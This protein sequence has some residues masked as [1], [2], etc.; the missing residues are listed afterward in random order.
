MKYFA[1]IILLAFLTTLLMGILLIPWL[2][3]LKFGQTVREDGPESHLA[4]SGTPTM[5]GILFLIP[6]ILIGLILPKGRG[7]FALAAVLS[8]A[9]FA[10]IGF[11]D[12]YIIVVKKRSLGLRAYQK[13]IGQ[14][15]V[16][17]ALAV[18]AYR[19]EYVGSS[20]IIPFTGAEWD[21]G[22]FYIPVMVFI[23]IGTVNSVNLTDG[24]D[25]LCGGV[26]LVVSAT[27]SII[28]GAVWTL[29]EKQGMLT[30]AENYQDLAIFA[31]ALTGACLGFLRFN[32]HPAQVF[33]GD[34]GSLGLG[35]AVSALSLLL[36]IP[37]WLP[38]IGGVYMAES[39]SVIIQ[40]ASFKLRGKRVF[41]MSPLHHHFELSGM[42]ETKVTVMF[43][44]AAVVLCL[45][46]LLNI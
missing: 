12:D 34:T 15:V 30:L 5:G 16:S 40:V 8:T 32:S 44:L 22:V 43:I 27:L 19:S 11:L 6:L 26:T 25:G 39:L 21:L 33:M 9:G 17:V 28:I 45:F 38:V 41:R 18:Y 10:L 46:A 1:S 7:S 42:P 20:V 31:A 14:L 4:K 3:R 29:A 2:R 13:I 35:G 23:I 37:L 24:L 36:R